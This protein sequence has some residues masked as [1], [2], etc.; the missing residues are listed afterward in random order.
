MQQQAISLLFDVDNVCKY[1]ANVSF[2][3]MYDVANVVKFSKLPDCVYAGAYTSP[4]DISPL[5]VGRLLCNLKST[6]P[7]A[8]GLP[9][10]FFQSCSV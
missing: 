8:D 10:W 5:S 1:F 6:S 2:D 9:C 7:G 3:S 4:T